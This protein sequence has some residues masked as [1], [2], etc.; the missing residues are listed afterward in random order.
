MPDIAALNAIG[1]VILLAEASAVF[2]PFMERRSDFGADVLARLDQGRLLS[3]TDYIQAQPALAIP[4]GF[5]QAGLP[6]GLQIIGRPYEE[7]LILRVGAALEDRTA[8][9]RRAPQI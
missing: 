8:H 7:A 4:C 6:L 2:E 5:S 1:R 9:H 3:A